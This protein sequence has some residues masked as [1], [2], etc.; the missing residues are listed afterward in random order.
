MLLLS[1][2]IALSAPVS[3]WENHQILMER[4]LDSKASKQRIY[5]YQKIKFPCVEEEKKEIEFLGKELKIDA[6]KIPVFSEKRCEPG[7]KTGEVI[8]SELIAS[9][10]VDEPDMGMDQN[11]PNSADPREARKW[12]GGSTGPTS[13]GFRH[14]IFPGIQVRSPVQSFQIPFGSVGDVLERIQKLHEVSKGYFESGNKF[15]GLRTLLWE[16]HYVQDLHQPF[17]V[18]QIPSMK[19]LPWKKLFS[20]FIN[21]ST[22][23]MANYHYAY[24]SLT[25]GM[26]KEAV[27]NGFQKCFEPEIL[28]DPTAPMDILDIPRAAAPKVGAAVYAALGDYMK[29]NEV[30]LPAGVG[31]IDTFTLLHATEPVIPL[32][33]DQK[34]ISSDEMKSIQNQFKQYKAISE[35]KTFSCELMSSLSRS[36]WEELDH[37]F[38][39]AQSPASNKSGKWSDA[40]P[41]IRRVRR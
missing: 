7:Q 28:D 33:S 25:Q 30:N 18:A 8:M 22:H 36:T 15:W 5:P 24:E 13:Q 2:L 31:Q 23:A 34:E 29:S 9:A 3:A 17:H 26:I 10:F 11:L 1:A 35:L 12:M 32:E 19:M 38:I 41:E 6:S 27:S 16:I 20:G 37:A 4:M 39:K 14:M 40:L 21:A